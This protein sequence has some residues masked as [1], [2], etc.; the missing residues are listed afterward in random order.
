MVFEIAVRHVF[1]DRRVEARAFAYKEVRIRALTSELVGPCGITGKDDCLSRKLDAISERDA[2]RV[3]VDFERGGPQSA[4]REPFVR[5]EISIFE[6]ERSF[7]TRKKQT[8]R[9][10]HFGLGPLGPENA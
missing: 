9:F 10:S 2:S 7:H 3:M 1:V 4:E 5:R 8:H 6:R